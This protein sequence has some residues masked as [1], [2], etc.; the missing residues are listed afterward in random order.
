[1]RLELA[2]RDEQRQACIQ[3]KAAGLNVR[4]GNPVD[5]GAWAVEVWPED[6]KPDALPDR[7]KA[8]DDETLKR[9][10]YRRRASGYWANE[11][12]GS[13]RTRDEAVGVVEC[14]M[15]IERVT[16]EPMPAWM[17]KARD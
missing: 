15:E 11:N 8:I 5:C 1:M 17:T 10:G 4:E 16:G 14:W 12:T 6:R 13:L 2:S 9:Y 3:V 7:P